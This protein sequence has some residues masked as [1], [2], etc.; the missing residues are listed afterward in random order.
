MVHTPEQNGV[1]ERK[2]R[3]ILNQ[4]GS[5]VHQVD[6]PARLWAEI[7]STAN[8]LIN[9]SPTTSNYGITLEQGFTGKT[10]DL[11]K[12]RVFGCDAYV[13]IPKSERKDKLVTRAKRCAL[14]GYDEASKAYRC[15][16][17]PSQR[18]I[19]TKDVSFD[20]ASYKGPN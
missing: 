15:F 8:F 4:A 18:L 20:E 12:L 3:T 7:L 19:V 13:F 5:M 9:A 16:D 17:P 2:N 1:S 11:S 6:L 14:I 10:P